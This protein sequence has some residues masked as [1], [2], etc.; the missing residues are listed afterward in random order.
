MTGI[1]DY[2]P[3]GVGALVWFGTDDAA[4]S[5][6][7]PVY[8]S[9]SK[10]PEC[11]RVGNGDMLHYSATSQFAAWVSLEEM[12]LLK[13]MDGNVKAQNADGSF[14]HSEYSTGIPV[15]ITNPPYVE[16][17]RRAVAESEHGSVL[18]AR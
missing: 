8:V 18:E 9:T 14:V 4:T 6:L 17:W 16:A 11:L 10:V 2:D 1:Q 3:G 13:Y 12:L 15:G 7:T 5:Y